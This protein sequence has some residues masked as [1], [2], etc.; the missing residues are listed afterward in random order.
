MPT[1]KKNDGAEAGVE[2][3][4]STASRDRYK[5]GVSVRT[6]DAP[7]QTAGANDGRSAGTKKEK[8]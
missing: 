1:K 3:Q 8:D 7:A 2:L 4:T 6:P 5:D